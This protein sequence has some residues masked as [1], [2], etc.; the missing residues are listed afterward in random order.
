[1]AVYG[2]WEA[3][4]GFSTLLIVLGICYVPSGPRDYVTILER[5][6]LRGSAWYLCG[7]VFVELG[8]LLLKFLPKS[9]VSQKLFP[10][11][12]RRYFRLERLW[13]MYGP[14]LLVIAVWSCN[15]CTAPEIGIGSRGSCIPVVGLPAFGLGIAYY[16][17]GSLRAN[18]SLKTPWQ[19]W[20]D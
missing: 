2:L 4:S 15:L 10:V 13:L 11:R 5:A 20:L 18:G 1:L 6:V 12:L 19:F 8:L 9:R 3:A 7:R 17:I 14:F 16:V